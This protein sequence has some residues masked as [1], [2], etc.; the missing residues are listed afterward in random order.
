MFKSNI[1]TPTK[2]PGIIN[3]KSVKTK[4]GKYK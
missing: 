3:T 2:V 4:K 1:D